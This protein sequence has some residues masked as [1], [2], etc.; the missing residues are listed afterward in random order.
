M[1]TAA[2]VPVTREEELEGEEALE[3]LRRTGRRRL[4]TDA[5]TRFRA[6]DGFSHSRALAFQVTLTVLPA[7]I[8]L[9][10][11]A[12][13]LEIESFTRVVRDTIRELAPGAVG[14]I[15]T[16]ALEQGTTAARQESGE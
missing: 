9:V 8:A 15:F 2:A 13:A 5:I 12:A 6:A 16:E 7:L 11:L 3:T 14:D 1:T 10:G 4:V